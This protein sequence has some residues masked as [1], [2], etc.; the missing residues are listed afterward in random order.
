MADTVIIP[1]FERILV[2]HAEVGPKAAEGWK[3]VGEVTRIV[4]EKPK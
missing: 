1:E 2:T 4:M 3:V